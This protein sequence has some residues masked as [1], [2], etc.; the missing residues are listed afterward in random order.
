MTE[1]PANDFE[2]EEVES[3]YSYVWDTP[4]PMAKQLAIIRQLFPNLGSAG[5]HLADRLCPPKAE[6]WFAIPRWQ[7][8]A[9]AYGE[10]LE[11]LLG[12]LSSSRSYLFMNWRA[13]KMGA[14][15]LRQSAKTEESLRMLSKEQEGHDILIVPA[16]LGYLHRGRSARR[17]RHLMD[18]NEFGLDTFTVCCILLTHSNRLMS[19]RDLKID[20]AGDEYASKPGDFRDVPI[21]YLDDEDD[22]N[23]G[24]LKLS[25]D[26][27]D[28]ASRQCGSA[29]GFLS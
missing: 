5:V 2:N 4:K 29:S 12:R 6:G 8:I 27:H 22:E 16:Q 19:Q 24:I 23:S 7:A 20:C 13:G 18:K 9:P 10:A 11:V 26:R 21:F 1:I 28:S 3:N 25:A 17:A 14:E 15:H